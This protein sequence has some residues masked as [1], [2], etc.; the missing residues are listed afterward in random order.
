MTI[1]YNTP[2]SFLRSFCILLIFLAFGC[3]SQPEATSS[4]ETVPQLNV[5]ADEERIVT[6]T[7]IQSLSDITINKVTDQMD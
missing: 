5:S 7:E 4:I 1:L 3:D 6:T 2:M